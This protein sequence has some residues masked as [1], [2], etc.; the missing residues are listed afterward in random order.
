MSDEKVEPINDEDSE[1]LEENK[2]KLKSMEEEL[3]QKADEFDAHKKS[4]EE[5]FHHREEKIVAIE[6]NLLQK[7]GNLDESGRFMKIQTLLDEVY[8]L[9]ICGGGKPDDLYESIKLILEARN[10]FSLH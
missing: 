5:E 7:T 4:I 2:R 8:T 9:F 6:E 10:K 1:R 3:K